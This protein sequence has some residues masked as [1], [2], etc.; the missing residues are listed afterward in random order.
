[1]LHRVA[2]PFAAKDCWLQDDLH[3]DSSYNRTFNSGGNKTRGSRAPARWVSADF[4]SLVLCLRGSRQA[5][6]ILIWE[7]DSP[8]APLQGTKLQ[9]PF[10]C[11]NERRLS[12]CPVETPEFVSS[13]RLSHSQHLTHFLSFI[14]RTF[15]LKFCPFLSLFCLP[16][17]SIPTL[18]CSIL[19]K[20]TSRRT[21]LRCLPLCFIFF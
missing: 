15:P 13:P 10:P 12:P 18:Q 11:D 7:L 5:Q 2:L 3:K 16:T 17:F 14:F 6:R 1:M 21:T 9:S 19:L 4:S 8:N 20:T